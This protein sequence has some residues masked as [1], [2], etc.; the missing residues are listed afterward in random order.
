MYNKIRLKNW[1]KKGKYKNI[2]QNYKG[3]WYQSRLEA[4]VAQDLDWRIKAGE[5]IEWKAQVK[6]D[7]KVN[8]LH[9]TNYYI[10]FVA[11][12][13]DGTKEYIEAKGLELPLWQLK[14]KLLEALRDEIMDKGDEM[15]VIKA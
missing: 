1:R 14:W 9:I 6:I 7:L 3:K 12:R 13:A 4:K 8:G 10:D 2:S 11:T 5:L 15:F